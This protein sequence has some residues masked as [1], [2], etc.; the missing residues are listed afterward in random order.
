MPPR[1]A[2]AGRLAAEGAPP[3]RD[4]PEAPEGRR[5]SGDL[6]PTLLAIPVSRAP[7]PRLV[8]PRTGPDRPTGP[9][10]AGAPAYRLLEKI[11]SGGTAVVYRAE[12]TLLGRSVALK[13]LAPELSCN[14]ES[15]ERFL[16]EARAA[17]ALDHPN[18][19]TIHEV[20]EDEEGRV[21]LCMPFYEGETLRERLERG[22]LPV[23]QAL[24]I[25]IQA[26]QGLARA[27]RQGIVHRDVKPANLMLTTDGVVKV[28]DFGLAKLDGA[29]RITRGTSAGGTLAYMS[30][31]QARGEEVDA[32]S[33]LWS[34]G[35]VLYEMV[36]GSKPF[37]GDTLQEVIATIQRAEP[38]PASRRR[39]GAPAELDRILARM[40]AKDPAH[41][42]P[43]LESAVLDLRALRGPEMSS[44][45]RLLAPVPRRK[46]LWRTAAQAGAAAAV[47]A[48]AVLLLWSFGPRPPAGPAPSSSFIPLTHGEGRE[49]SPSLA[50]EG[51]FFVYTAR[52][53]GDLDIFW[54]RIGGDNA[55]NLTEG[56]PWDDTQPAV[57]P[58]G[59]QIAFRSERQGGGLFVMGATGE[60]VRRLAGFGYNPSWSP[61]GRK[62]VCASEG[63]SGPG[64]RVSHSSLWQIDLETGT[65]QL[66]TPEDG[67]QPNW[68]P[69]GHRIAWW[70]LSG[71]SARRALW[72]IAAERLEEDRPGAG[73]EPVLVL[74]DEHLNW[75]PVW[76]SD[77]GWLYFASD[78]GGSMNLWRVK[79]D[80]ESGRVLGE[81]E[82]VTAPSTTSV[83]PSLARDGRRIAFAGESEK[84]QLV[85]VPFDPRRRQAAGPA[86][87][88]IQGSRVV[89]S[90]DV[91][92]D[93]QWVVFDTSAPQEDLFVVRADGSGLRQ[94]TDDPFRDRIPR[95]SPD[96]RRILFYSDRGG[97]YEAWSLPVEGGAAK[98]LTNV[99]GKRLFD[100]VWSPDSR[101]LI[102]SLEF[103]GPYVIDL[104]NAA[105]PPRLLLPLEEAEDFAVSSW[106]P[107]GR[108]LAGFDR[109]SRI[110]LFSFAT[111]R[112]EVLPEKGEDVAWLPDGR[113]LVYLRGGAV[114][115]LDLATRRESAVLAPPAGSAFTRLGAAPDGRSLY[116]VRV[117]EEG[118]IGLLTLP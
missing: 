12:D 60:S 88:V 65:R 87:A 14:P 93:G 103:R 23:D 68:S 92:P 95:W 40:L 97:K 70:G 62:I 96:G 116:L 45:R 117:S 73:D 83:L 98:Q 66:V 78:R 19:C 49:T 39:S 33:D 42:Y 107:D 90:G 74:D 114:W 104:A 27:H 13:F 48:A 46:R 58:D 113:S 85:R 94:L 99:P 55:L 2:T 31:E 67:V 82:A 84:S 26:G 81:P 4:E 30:P 5:G 118:D 69:H 28:L 72:T 61:D 25:A 51:D 3:C 109:A 21:F 22:P 1:F 91:S 115:S 106:S 38:E 52:S 11:G 35:V 56:S 36:A 16:R 108:R 34:L 17:S 80:E 101:R 110:V 20:G 10:L 77:G 112:R 32:R 100:P 15:K 105:A 59:Q 41:R 24:A 54:Q 79:I 53:G 102:C 8:R 89:R 50:P 43:D 111:G 47:A 75:S 44:G 64:S 29:A 18:L 7:E 76:S 6:Q 86:Q 57:S 63:V 9:I 71:D 37:S